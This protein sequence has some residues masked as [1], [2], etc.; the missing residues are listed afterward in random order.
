M[1]GRYV[2]VVKGENATGTGLLHA[3]TEA[4][5][6]TGRILLSCALGL[7]RGVNL[8]LIFLLVLL[9]GSRLQVLVVYGMV[10]LGIG[11]GVDLDEGHI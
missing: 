6:S 11:A 9:V 1:D 8:L 10:R 3:P 2:G 7:P 5:R 4:A